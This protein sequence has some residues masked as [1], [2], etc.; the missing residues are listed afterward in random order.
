MT[1]STMLGTVLAMCMTTMLGTVINH[2]V[3]NIMKTTIGHNK[4]NFKMAHT[5]KNMDGISATSKNNW[6]TIK[7]IK[8]KCLKWK[9]DVVIKTFVS[10]IYSL[11]HDDCCTKF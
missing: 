6:K 2:I 1:T 8:F 4:S 10:Y 9:L 7:R 3:T 5:L 11:K